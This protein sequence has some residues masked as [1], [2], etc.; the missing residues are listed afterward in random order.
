MSSNSDKY[1]TESGR[2]RFIKGVVG[3]S[4]LGAVGTLGGAMATTATSSTG[5]GGGPTKFFGIKNTGGPAPRGM[6]QIPIEIDDNGALK[7]VFPEWQTKTVSGKEVQVS[8]TEIAGYTYG[9]NWFQY[10]GVQT[11]GGL[12][13]D[14]DEQNFFRSA[15]SGMYSWQSE[16]PKGNK[17]KVEHFGDYKTWGNDVGKSGIGKPAQATWRSQNTKST[18]PVQ[19]IRS[20][21]VKQLANGDSKYSD[22]LKET[23]EKGFIAWMDKC[24]HYCCVPG[25]KA[26]GASEK[27]GAVN[28]VYCP[29]HQSIYD[30]FTIVRKT[31][32]A[33]PR[34]GGD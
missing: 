13:P 34:P 8:K 14:A 23:T 7:G 25:F 20:E 30:P 31:F 6:P 28:E 9:A 10:C 29:C 26:Y 15:G 17:L 16:V 3:A 33:L 22:W 4:A 21:K 11:Y 32:T 12:Q 2:R 5:E 19:I 18:I 24:T 1:P 27:F